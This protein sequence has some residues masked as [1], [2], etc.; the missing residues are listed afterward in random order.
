MGSGLGELGVRGA[1][2]PSESLRE[3]RGT[4]AEN[5]ERKRETLD[6]V[7]EV[8]GTPSVPKVC[9]SVV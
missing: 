1:M 2:R 3:R 9:L 7:V 6:F 8:C 5:K 4:P